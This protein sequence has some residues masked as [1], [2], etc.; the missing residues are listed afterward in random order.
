MKIGS[1]SCLNKRIQLSKYEPNIH[2]SNIG[3]CRKLSHHTVKG[4]KASLNARETL[5][6]TACDMTYTDLIKSVVVTSKMD[7]LTVTA[8]SKK[9]G[10]KKDV[11]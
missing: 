5:P 6:K 1:F 8:A 4:I 9:K 10:L 7:R 3:S 2:H 11:A